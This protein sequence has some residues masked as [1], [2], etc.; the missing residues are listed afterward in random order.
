MKK[1]KSSFLVCAELEATKGDKSRA[2]QVLYSGPDRKKAHA[3]AERELHATGGPL[4]VFKV[5][6]SVVLASDA[7]VASLPRKAF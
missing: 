3:T 4:T 6:R 7:L 2:F 5:S 1:A